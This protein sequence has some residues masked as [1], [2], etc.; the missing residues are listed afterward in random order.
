MGAETD[1][2]FSEAQRAN[3]GLHA[4]LCAWA[5]KLEHRF[6]V[7]VFGSARLADQHHY[8]D[9]IKIFTA[10]LAREAIDVVTGGGPGVMAAANEGVVRSNSNSRSFGVPLVTLTNGEA[11]NN[12]TQQQF[13]AADF[14]FRLQCFGACC[15]AFVCARGGIGTLLELAMV[16]Q[17]CQLL[18]ANGDMGKLLRSELSFL[19][20]SVRLAG[21]RP[22]IVVVGVETWGWMESMYRAMLRPDLPTIDPEDTSLVTIVDNFDEAARLLIDE[23]ATWRNAMQ[24]KGLNPCN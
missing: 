5:D 13:P 11:P 19:H 24:R 12:W 18:R 22:K 8:A 7:G 2:L 14:F 4:S 10:S 23:R 1:R 3:L 20:P 16:M 17:T 21:Y 6:R 15:T 9:E